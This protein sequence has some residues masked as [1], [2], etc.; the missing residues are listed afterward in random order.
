MANTRKTY[1]VNGLMEWDTTIPVGKATMKVHFS[2]GSLTGYGVT[3]ATFTTEDPMKQ[4]I[5]EKSDY[6]K[7]GKIFVVREMEGT[8]KYKERIVEHHADAGTH[9]GG[10]AA[11]AGAVMESPLNPDYQQEEA[12]AVD[13]QGTVSEEDGMTVVEVT[14][15]DAARDYLAETFGIAR[16][17]IRYKSN[18]LEMAEKLKVKFVGLDE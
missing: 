2:G 13:A 4:M 8:G 10:V 3:P 16:S 7:S 11:T 18:V 12:T 15:I 14:D 9:M 5:I 6:F 1:G 17:N